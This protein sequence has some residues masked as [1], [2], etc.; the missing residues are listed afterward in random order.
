M[1]FAYYFVNY[2]SRLAFKYNLCRWS[3]RSRTYV[4]VDDNDADDNNDHKGVVN[5]A[6]LL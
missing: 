4:A 6:S 5:W 2:S 1:Y 3:A